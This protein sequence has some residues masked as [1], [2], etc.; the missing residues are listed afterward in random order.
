MSDFQ[1]IPGRNVQEYQLDGD[2]LF[3]YDDEDHIA[4]D[5]Y[6]ESDFHFPAHFSIQVVTTKN[7]TFVFDANSH[8]TWPLIAK[9]LHER[10]QAM[11]RSKQ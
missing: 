8:G 7:K 4:A 9:R 11:L 2:L 5:V 6:V 1:L 10:H 3:R